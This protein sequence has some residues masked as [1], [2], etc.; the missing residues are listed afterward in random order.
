VRLSPPA[1]LCG[2]RGEQTRAERFVRKAAHRHERLRRR[3]PPAQFRTVPLRLEN[4]RTTW[5]RRVS[6]SMVVVPPPARCCHCGAT[7]LQPC[8]IYLTRM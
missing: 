7:D 6:N 8:A 5:P 3:G 1:A 4:A 2:G